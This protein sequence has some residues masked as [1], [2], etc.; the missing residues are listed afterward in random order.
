MISCLNGYV[1]QN[2]PSNV[3]LLLH[4]GILEELDTEVVAAQ[5]HH[6]LGTGA[7]SFEE[8]QVH[9]GFAQSVAANVDHQLERR[10]SVFGGLA[11]RARLVVHGDGGLSILFPVPQLSNPPTIN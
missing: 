7:R 8:E 10:I 2:S 11:P 1:A 6:A 5:G 3:H 4:H 9:A